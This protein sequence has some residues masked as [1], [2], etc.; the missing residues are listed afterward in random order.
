VRRAVGA[1]VLALREDLPGQRAG[2]APRR[3]AAVVSPQAIDAADRSG[4]TRRRGVDQM[5]GRAQIAARSPACRYSAGRTMR[6]LPSRLELHPPS[7][8]RRPRRNDPRARVGGSPAPPLPRD[9]LRNI[10]VS[11]QAASVSFLQAPFRLSQGVRASFIK[12]TSKASTTQC[13]RGETPGRLPPAA[14]CP[15]RPARGVRRWP[16]T[17][18]E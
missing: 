2:L 12:T 8:R 18:R 3:L 15:Q 10:Q 9:T 4:R 1:D 14:R 13:R 17:R 16:R 6:L 11:K 7:R 5:P